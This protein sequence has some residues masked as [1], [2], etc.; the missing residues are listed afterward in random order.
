MAGPA[1]PTGAPGPP[2]PT[3][4]VGQ[5]RVV[6]GEFVVPAGALNIDSVACPAGTGVISGGVISVT[7]GGTWY[8][9]PSGNGW[10]GASDNFDGTTAGSHRIFAVCAAGAPVPTGVLSA[11]ERQELVAAKRASLER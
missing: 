8:D 11:A 5:T 9:A 1:G 4:F 6:S 10:A 3:G 2:G 7:A